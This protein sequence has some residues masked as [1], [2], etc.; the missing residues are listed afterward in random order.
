MRVGLV[1][2]WQCFLSHQSLLLLGKDRVDAVRCLSVRLLEV[3]SLC[4]GFSGRVL[5]KLPFLGTVPSQ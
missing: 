3:A 1:A 4:Q 5:R 2:P